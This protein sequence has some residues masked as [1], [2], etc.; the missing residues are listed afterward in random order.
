MIKLEEQCK[1]ICFNFLRLKYIQKN[2]NHEEIFTKKKNFTSGFF[3]ES[4]T[5]LHNTGYK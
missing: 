1:Y 5:T 3:I 2:I 4:K